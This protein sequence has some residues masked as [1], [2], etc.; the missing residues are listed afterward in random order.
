MLQGATV[1]VTY[2]TPAG[3]VAQTPFAVPTRARK[4]VKVNDVPGLSNTDC[5][6]YRSERRFGTDTLGDY[7]N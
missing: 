2:M 1:S 6:M 7:S 5:S 4:T 3:P